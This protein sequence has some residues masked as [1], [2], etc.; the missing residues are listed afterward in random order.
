MIWELVAERKLG[1]GADSKPLLRCQYTTPQGI[2]DKT[3]SI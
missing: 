2:M 3:L 1:Q